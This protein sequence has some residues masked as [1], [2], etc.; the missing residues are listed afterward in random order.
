MRQLWKLALILGV[1]SFSAG[2]A[3]ADN[4]EITYTKHIAPLIQS[5]CVECH[6]AQGLAPM[7]FQSYDQVRAWAKSIRKEVHEGRMPPWGLD[8]NVGEW[9]NDPTLSKEELAMLDKWMDTGMRQGDP[10]DLP[11]PRVFHDDWSISKPDMIFEMPKEIVI[12]AEGVMPYQYHVTELNNEEDLYVQ[13]LEVL[14]GNRKV[15]HHIIV[16]L[17]PPAEWS[18]E[19]SDGFTANFLDVY[20][21]G[22]PAGKNPPGVARIIPKGSKLMWQVHYTPTGQEE[23]DQSKFGIVLAKEEPKELMNTALMVNMGFKI[24]PM[25]EDHVVEAKTTI[26]KDATIYSFTPHMHYRGKAMDFFLTRPGGEEELVCSIP[27][28]D[29]NWQLDYF[30]KEPMKVPAGTVVR[31]VGRF[32]NSPKN[33]YNPDPTKEVK[34]GEQTWEEMLMGGVFLSMPVDD[35][36]AASA[37][38]AGN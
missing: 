16:F 5:K 23:R 32:D 17:Q 10:K 12:P 13:E 30:L 25:V 6:R 34:W 1:C 33:P 4:G 37:G 35:E 27:R 26:K 15:V 24:P 38:G 8:P 20:A 7:D 18:R 21:P 36:P 29:F 22:S 14:P 31:I 3:R 19:H 9:A 11:E 2:L 28:Y